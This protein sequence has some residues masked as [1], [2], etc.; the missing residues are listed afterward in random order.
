MTRN[1]I[2]DGLT[3]TIQMFLFNANTGEIFTEPRNDMD[4]ITIDACKGA[5]KLLEQGAKAGHWIANNLYYQCS[6]CRRNAPMVETGCL[7]NRHLEALLTDFCP[8]CGA[9]M[10]G[11]KE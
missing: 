3:F 5:I 8:N 4:K 11:D 10:R 1:E 2:I 9:D 6:C 7:M